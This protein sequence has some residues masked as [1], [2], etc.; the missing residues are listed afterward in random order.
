MRIAFLSWRDTTHPDGGGSEVF[1]EAVGRELVLRGH[2]VTLLCSRHPGSAPRDDLDGIRLRRLGGRLTVYLWGLAWLVWHR[3]DVD[4][5]VDVVNGL[6]FASPLVRRKGVVALVHHVH[7]EQWRIIYPGLAGRIGWFVE[8]RIV[9]LL[10]RGRPFLTVSDASARDLVAIGVDAARI[11]VVRNG[12]VA[13]PAEVVEESPLP[14]LAVLSRLVPHKQIEHALTVVH[15]LSAEFPDLHLDVVGDGWWH[16]ELATAA[17]ALDVTD[18]VT[19]HGH[20]SD[21]RRDQLV[22]EAW[23]MVM[24]SIKEGWCLAIT[25]SGAQGTP[26][27]AY[28]EAGGVTE[29]IRDGVT[30]RLAADLD[31]LVGIVRELLTDHTTRSRMG[32]AARRMA[33]TLTWDTCAV[34]AEVVLRAAGAPNDQSP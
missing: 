1:V 14:R 29:S 2:A 34:R 7:A 12:L 32:V 15:R 9:P 10:Y 27:V 8:S 5:V 22:G 25:E 4:V 31:D 17:E 16:D 18:R 28:A 23:L 24:P 3:R 21:A 13:V 26:S 11:T 19:F 30:G 20:V 33:R 6:P